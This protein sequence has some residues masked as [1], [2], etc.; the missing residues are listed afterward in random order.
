MKKR[1]WLIAL[2]LLLVLALIPALG[3]R[4]EAADV[5]TINTTNFPDPNF[6]IFVYSVDKDGNGALSA[7]ELAAVTKIDVYG[8]YISDMKGIEYFTSLKELY[9]GGNQFTKVDLSKNTA[10]EKLYCY[11]CSQLT[12]LDVSKLSALNSLDLQ[13]D[14]AVTYVA[15]FYC[16]LSYLNVHGCTSLQYLYC[17][18]NDLSTLDVTGCTS[19]KILNCSNNRLSSLDF[20]R[21][22]ALQTLVC[23]DNQLT[24]LSVSKHSS[25]DR[26]KVSNNP[27]MTALACSN[28]ALTTLDVSGCTAMTD[29]SCYSN[30]LTT[31]DVSDCT[32]L[33]YLD[34]D[35]NQLSSLDVSSNTE[36]TS[37]FCSDNRLTEL[38]VSK[39]EALE[40]LWC[41]NNLLTELEVEYSTPLKSLKAG[42]NTR[43][44]KVDCCF[45]PV[46]DLEVAG[47]TA[48][49]ELYCTNDR[50]TALDVSGLSALKVL[51]CG[52]D[53]LA[54]L[55][56]TGC[57]ALE[58]LHC[59][60]CELT[61]L[62]ISDCTA[63]KEL[64]CGYSSLTE[65]DVTGCPALEELDCSYSKLTSLDVTGCPALR[66]LDC[67][68][69]LTELDVSNC[70][71]LTYLDC[72]NSGLA[73]L[74]VRNCPLLT[75]LDCRDNSIPLLDI[76]NCSCLCAVYLEQSPMYSYDGKTVYYED[77]ETENTELLAVDTATVILSPKPAITAQP[78]NKTAAAGSTVKFTVGA[79]GDDLSYQ[80]QFC[81]PGKTE[82]NNSSMTGNKTATLTVEATTARNGQKYRCVVTNSYGSA[83]SKEAKLTVVTKPAITTQPKS[84]TAAAGTTAKFTV[85]A[86]GGNLT[87]QWQFKAPGTTA[88]ND[89]GMTGNK[90]ATLSVPVTSARNGQQ[91]RCVVKN[92]AGSVTSNAATLTV[93]AKPAITTQ[94]QNKTAAAGT[95]VKF[96]VA[97]SGSGLS[98]QWQFKAP[99]TTTWNNSS[100][101]G[102][103]TATLS[104]E[105]TTAR[106]G[107]Q[108]RCIVKNSA[109]SVT[110][111]AAKL[112][113]VT[114][115]SITAQPKNITA[116]PGDVVKFT[117][118]ATGGGLSY[119]WQ[120]KSPSSSTW[121]DSGMTGAKTATL[122][123]TAESARNGQQYRCVVKNAAGSATSNAG[124]LT[125]SA[126]AKPTIMIDPKSVTA[127]AGSTV[128]FTVEASGGSGLKYQWQFKAP[129]T[130]TWYDSSM[131]GAKTATLTVTATAARS[132]QQYR[133]IVTNSHGTATSAAAKLTVK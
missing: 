80:W 96:T 11:N 100:M 9:C 57:P 104:V 69:D 27:G 95:T 26:L 117:V 25:L 74:D 106:N 4:A 53:T 75:Y 89:S 101:T 61:S 8:K 124:K 132:G 118:S 84:V 17:Y 127:S 23:Q 121:K 55:D 10:L 32:A 64:F 128:K 12:S 6:R 5:V 66:L 18:N 119:Q 131:T 107:Q 3:S 98:Y 65:L 85:A 33:D 112:T 40:L 22:T 87:Y 63:L 34:C 20:S 130:D 49:K 36:L 97:A 91:Y 30:L 126:S 51:I 129:G 76:R 56:L 1:L 133:C 114:K 48:L 54:E 16:D 67:R 125:V 108:Y 45:C 102:A 71:A 52:Y 122:T 43:L 70:P 77:P 38:D 28:C 47:C 83:T 7:S 123:V 113:V 103:K 99:G 2:S 88:W 92:A 111:N 14:T 19:L 46:T 24:K 15:C 82:W 120:Y 31:L 116:V 59:P 50:L 29:L 115:P 78:Q 37:L 21:N 110:S 79:A 94:P 35:D 39:N 44:E 41:K 72:R 60:H 42:G 93:A 86:S 109:G 58:K 68:N 81:A 105:A 73:A 13:N 90:T 62:D